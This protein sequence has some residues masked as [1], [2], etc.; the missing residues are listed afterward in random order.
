MTKPST[1]EAWLAELGQ[2][3]ADRDYKPGHE[4]MLA[5]LSDA[6]L[7][8]PRL[9][10]RVVGTNGKGSTS[11]MLAA[12]LTA[13]GYKVGLYTSPHIQRFNERIRIN[14]VPVNDHALHQLLTR[15]MP[16]A[17]AC[18]ASYFEVATALALLHFSQQ[19]VDVEILE[20]GVGARLDATHA[21]A[22][23]LAL[24]TPIGLD[25][26]AWLGDTLTSIATE[27]A[28]AMQGCRHSISAAQETEVEKC[29]TDSGDVVMLQR[30]M[31]WPG[32]AMPGK[33]QE[34]NA[35]L[36][37]AA[38][39]A[40]NAGGWL[41]VDL[42]LA[43]GAITHCRVPG[44]LQHM[45]FGSADIWLDAAHNRHAVQAL[46]PIL[47]DLANPFDA[48][49]VWTREDRS[50]ADVLE[51]LRPYAHK[52]ISNDG[53]RPQ[54]QGDP[55]GPWQSLQQA[56]LAC[57]EGSFLALGSFTTVAAILPHLERVHDDG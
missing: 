52:L 16:V 40:I 51:L 32:L 34:D 35:Q 33:H 6:S 46:L 57:P 53:T 24:I 13:C 55:A 44:R 43:R 27:K 11:C 26:Q 15:L 17:R 18:E 30:G 7:H 1:I 9:R 49:L 28:Y 39:Q 31:A 47:S 3:A 5:L 4:R 19:Q 10:V 56:M 45:R 54:D 14:N 20:A 21:V 42:N 37:F 25:H 22:A 36:A 29:L 38:V 8:T 41:A 2:P 48:I 12:A 23:D 50:L